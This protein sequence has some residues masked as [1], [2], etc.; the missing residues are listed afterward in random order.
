MR[1]ICATINEVMFESF[2]THQSAKKTN[3]EQNN[4]QLRTQ[5]NEFRNKFVDA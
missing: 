4:K 1:L 3:K 2:A 5:S